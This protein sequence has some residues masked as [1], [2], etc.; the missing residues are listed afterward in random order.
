MGYAKAMN[1]DIPPPPSSSNENRQ[2]EQKQLSLPEG[3][4]EGRR[5]V[6]EYVDILDQNP[7][8]ALANPALRKWL[9]E[10]AKTGFVNSVYYPKR[11]GN[12]I[13]PTIAL[14][15]W[16][17]KSFLLENQLIDP[18]RETMSRVK[19]IFS[20]LPPE[21]TP[22]PAQIVYERFFREYPQETLPPYGT[23]YL[24][25][26][27]DNI[28]PP[29]VS[30]KLYIENETL[31]Q[32]AEDG[33]LE[34]ALSQLKAEDKLPNKVKMFESRSLVMYF[35]SDIHEAASTFSTLEEL[36]INYRGPAQDTWQVVRDNEDNLTI[37]FHTSNDGALGDADRNPITYESDHYSPQ[38]FEENYARLCLYAGKNPAEPYTTSFVYLL[39]GKGPEASQEEITR[40]EPLAGYPIVAAPQRLTEFQTAE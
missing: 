27:G 10:I 14:P 3:F 25:K 29:P 24:V 22:K 18:P 13:D 16:L 7:Q 38:A 12:P 9:Q 40:A 35:S 26:P 28:I 31:T 30:F 6:T 21:N 11:E 15:P 34:K 32:A 8:E 37:G 33:R 19:R 17:Q 20:G 36:G 23:F 4:L 39:T 2:E 1:W 5:H